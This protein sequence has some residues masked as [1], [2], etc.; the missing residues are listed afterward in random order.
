VIAIVIQTDQSSVLHVRVD[1]DTIEVVPRG[2]VLTQTKMESFFAA[3]IR[4]AGTSSA[5]ALRAPDVGN[6]DH[7]QDDY[8]DDGDGD[9][10]E[11]NLDAHFVDLPC[12]QRGVLLPQ[13]PVL[14]LKLEYN[15]RVKFGKNKVG[16][17]T[18]ACMA[19]ATPFPG[20]GSIHFNGASF[21]SHFTKSKRCAGAAGALYRAGFKSTDAPINTSQEGAQ[22]RAGMRCLGFHG[23]RASSVVNK[24]G[25]GWY[26]DAGMAGISYMRGGELTT[27][28]HAIRAVSVE[29]SGTQSGCQGYSITADGL[30]D[31]KHCCSKCLKV[32]ESWEFKTVAERAKVSASKFTNH[33]H[34][35]NQDL[36]ARLNAV[37]TEK[38]ALSRA[39]ASA[40]R[41]GVKT[42]DRL[43]ALRSAVSEKN[44]DRFLKSVGILSEHGSPEELAIALGVCGDLMDG[45]SRKAADKALGTNSARGTRWSSATKAVAAGLQLAGGTKAVNVLRKNIAMPSQD[46]TRRDLRQ[47]GGLVSG[48]STEAVRNNVRV[49]LSLM[50]EQA[51]LLIEAGKMK[52]GDD[53]LVSFAEDEVPLQPG[54]MYDYAEKCFI[55]LCGLRAGDGEPEHKCA[56]EAEYKFAPGLTDQQKLDYIIH[57]ATN[58]VAGNYGHGVM[59][60]PI[61]GDMKPIAVLFGTTCN[62]FDANPTVRR[63]QAMVKAIFIEEVAMLEN[64]LV[65]FVAGGVGADGDARKFLIMLWESYR[66]TSIVIGPQMRPEDAAAGLAVDVADSV[67][68]VVGDSVDD[69]VEGA[70][71]DPAVGP[72]VQYN[73]RHYQFPAASFSNY[74]S[75]IERRV[76]NADGTSGRLVELVGL[77]HQDHKHNAKKLG[78]VLWSKSIRF[79]IGNYEVSITHLQPCVKANL[80]SKAS[81][82]RADRQNFDVIQHVTCNAVLDDLDHRA[83]ELGEKTQGCAF[84]LRVIRKYTL[85]YVAPPSVQCFGNERCPVC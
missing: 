26:Y 85:V 2:R 12:L 74:M 65:N 15:D 22:C 80:L 30:P 21:M 42:R 61:H 73:E 75:F 70:D 3:G 82:D 49:A 20:F 62:R 57:L 51:R 84:M 53:I 83:L 29:D 55:G 71:V 64:P 33:K 18:A 9:S 27:V 35:A 47:F 39:L 58:A 25:K 8:D 56:F 66:L 10:A 54:C 59:A 31:H 4:A 77:H 72:K 40:V 28:E 79:M 6:S 23:T 41:V 45:A 16:G 37:T 36:L 60:N 32:G 48:G 46:T 63:E 11:V 14:A 13:D 43:D 81:F 76:K 68:A 44:V 52:K 1:D 7:Y 67:G 19:C 34:L 38:N 78:A 69:V 5:A 24:R 50:S 17:D